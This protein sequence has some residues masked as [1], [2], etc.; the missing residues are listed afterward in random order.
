MDN[1]LVYDSKFLRRPL[2]FKNYGSNCWLNTLLNIL[3][4]CPSFNKVLII[5]DT[6]RN[7]KKNKIL[8]NYL[9]LFNKPEFQNKYMQKILILLTELTKDEINIK[10]KC[11]DEIFHLFMDYIEYY[12]LTHLFTNKFNHIIHCMDC[13]HQIITTDTTY[14]IGCF[15]GDNIPNT[16]MEYGSYIKTSRENLIDYKCDKCQKNNIVKLSKLARIGEILIIRFTDKYLNGKHKINY[17]EKIMFKSADKRTMV[18]NLVAEV[19]QIGNNNSGHYLTKVYQYDKKICETYLIS[20][21]LV[22]NSTFEVNKNTVLLFYH[23]VR[24][25]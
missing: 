20:D 22:E 9:K 17:L 11:F 3:L 15:N 2:G 19:I 25:E 13:K 4:N 6:T 1:L 16:P 8:S 18:Y 24:I 21:E 23:L 10:Q 12:K 5:N 7:I 14:V